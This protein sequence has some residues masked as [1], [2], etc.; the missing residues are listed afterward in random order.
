MGG[1]NDDATAAVSRNDTTQQKME[2]FFSLHV[3]IACL[4]MMVD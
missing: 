2:V 1:S 3:Q 4:T